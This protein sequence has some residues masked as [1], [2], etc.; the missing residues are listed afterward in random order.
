MEK[1]QYTTTQV[2]GNNTAYFPLFSIN[3]GHTKRHNCSARLLTSS[4]GNIIAVRL[5]TSSNGNIIAV[6]TSMHDV[7]DDSVNRNGGDTIVT[8]TAGRY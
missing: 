1:A 5:L 2:S 6:S 3:N 8:G 7:R 4:N